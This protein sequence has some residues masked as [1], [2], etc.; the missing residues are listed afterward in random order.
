ML[1]QKQCPP[2]GITATLTHP[3][4]TLILWGLRL[5]LQ[6]FLSHFGP[7][8]AS[9]RQKLPNTGEELDRC[10]FREG[11]ENSLVDIS[12]L[13]ELF[14]FCA[15]AESR[16]RIIGPFLLWEG[17][18]SNRAL[19]YEMH[20]LL[21]IFDHFVRFLMAPYLEIGAVWPRGSSDLLSHCWVWGSRKSCYFG[22][23]ATFIFYHL[24]T[25]MFLNGV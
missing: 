1:S 2:D 13:M 22:R 9:I 7:F 5:I 24:R 17:S 16:C 20:P 10:G 15:Q 8:R 25:S 11:I 19:A 23:S 3:T 6:G 4:S 21:C 18:F 14:G 12:W